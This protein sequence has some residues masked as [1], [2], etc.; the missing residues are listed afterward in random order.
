MR[1]LVLVMMLLHAP[2][3][4]EV[5]VNSTHVTSLR[6]AAK[7]PGERAYTD[8]ANCHI[9]TLDGKSVAVVETCDEVLAMMGR[10]TR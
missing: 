2:G 5:Q 10:E 8:Q 7:P 1:G 4:R 3:G 6:P 9:S